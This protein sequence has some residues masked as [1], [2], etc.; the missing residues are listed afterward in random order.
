MTGE[1]ADAAPHGAAPPG[2]ALPLLREIY[3]AH[4]AYV[5][6]TLRRLGVRER[7]IEDS[8][9]EVFVSLYKRIADY[10]PTRPLRPWIFAFAQRTASG[11]RARAGHQREIVSERI[12]FVDEG[13][14]P[15]ERIEAERR[16]ALVTEALDAIEFDRR[17]VFV[18]HEIDGHSIPEVAAT[19]A[20]PL[21][22]AYS[23]LRLARDEFGRAI[24]RLTLRAK[25]PVRP[26]KG[27]EP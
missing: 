2:D 22:T 26:S 23:R 25:S 18:M 20:I 13:P 7:D 1:R 19:L 15:D 9:Q 27:G 5:W 21:N 17:T 4:G 24:Q 6:N 10:D 12:D 14:R 16:R 3:D 8:V 11:Y